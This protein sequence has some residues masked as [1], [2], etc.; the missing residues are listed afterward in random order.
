LKNK[1]DHHPSKP[2]S[3]FQVVFHSDSNRNKNILFSTGFS[4]GST[5]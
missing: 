1:G 5:F 2:C 3:L 4:K